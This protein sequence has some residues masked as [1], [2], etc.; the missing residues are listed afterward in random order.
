MQST[1]A[2]RYAAA[3]HQIAREQ[4]LTR[5]ISEQL[6]ELAKIWVNQPDF[7][8]L[9]TSPRIEIS[10]KRST[11]TELGDRL[12]FGKPMTNLINL[13]LDKGRID[14]IPALAEEF[15]QLDDS[16]LGR[17][18]ARCISA[19]PLAEQQLDLLRNALK[20]VTGTKEVLI[21]LETEP[22]LLAGFVVS[23]DGKI[24]D[25]SLK[26]RLERLQRRL[27]QQKQQG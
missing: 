11:L 19:R 24:I 17:A 13:M 7:K 6:E 23:I 2:K 10:R 27:T 14:I 15:R 18:R 1:A 26:G 12:Q 5:Q 9:M 21:T 4:K 8:A 3:L 25:G 22:S 16:L 20:K